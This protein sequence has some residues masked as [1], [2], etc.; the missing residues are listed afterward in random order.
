MKSDSMEQINEKNKDQIPF[1]QYKAMLVS[2]CQ[3]LTNITT[4]KLCMYA[5]QMRTFFI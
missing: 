4:A 5:S 1:V 3:D 2:T